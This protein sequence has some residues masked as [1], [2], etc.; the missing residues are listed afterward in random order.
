[1]PIPGILTSRSK[2]S[3]AGFGLPLRRQVPETFGHAP[4][5]SWLQGILD[6]QEPSQPMLR[7]S[8][9]AAEDKWGGRVALADDARLAQFEDGDHILVEG[10]F[11]PE[12]TASDETNHIPLYR[13]QEVWLVKRQP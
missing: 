7:F 5:Y 12:E 13:I 8:Y 11:D 6:K 1:M 9:R 4:D 3:E 10:T 2:V